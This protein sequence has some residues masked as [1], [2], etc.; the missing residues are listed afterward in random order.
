MRQYWILFNVLINNMDDGV[1]SKFVDVI[2][3]RVAVSALEGRAGIIFSACWR[4]ELSQN[5]Y[6]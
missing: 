4:N 3:C 1:L 2:K 5:S 6:S